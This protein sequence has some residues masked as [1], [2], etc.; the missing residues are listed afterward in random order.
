[1][2]YTSIGN[3]AFYIIIFNGK[4]PFEIAFC[5]SGQ[6]KTISLQKKTKMK[7]REK[8]LKLGENQNQR[9]TDV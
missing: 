1:M 9:K 2:N 6:N 3:H 4:K 5:I 8:G 7:R